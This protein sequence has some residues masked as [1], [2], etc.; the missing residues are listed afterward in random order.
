M[1]SQKIIYLD[2]PLDKALDNLYEF[3]HKL[4]GYANN[5]GGIRHGKI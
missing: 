5:Y 4:Y 2:T 1:K 3:G